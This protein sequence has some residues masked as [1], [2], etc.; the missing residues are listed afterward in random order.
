[1]T[2][3]FSGKANCFTKI[4]KNYSVSD[5][6]SH[7]LDTSTNKSDVTRRRQK[8]Y[9]FHNLSLKERKGNGSEASCRQI[10][11]AWRGVC[12][13]IWTISTH[14]RCSC[15]I[16]RKGSS[17]CSKLVWKWNITWT[18]WMKNVDRVKTVSSGTWIKNYNTITGTNF[19]KI[20]YFE[21][22]LEVG[23]KLWVK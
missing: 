22:F 15:K 16:L 8:T 9:A 1:M 10:Q 14:V 13:Q 5:V 6:R 19:D 7:S 2:Y 3:P 12:C 20:F 18:M 11:Q 23:A 4:S 21:E 17:H